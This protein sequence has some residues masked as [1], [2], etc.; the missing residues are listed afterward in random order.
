M[1]SKEIQKFYDLW[2]P[3]IASLPAV[4]NAIDT[5]EELTRSLQVRRAEFDQLEA[6]RESREAELL[7]HVDDIKLRLQSAVDQAEADKKAARASADKAKTAAAEVEKKANER[8]AAAE[9]DAKKAEQL[10]RDAE[11]SRSKVFAQI[12]E[13]ALARKNA[14]QAEIDE[15][16]NKRQEA[17]ATLNALRFKLG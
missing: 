10:Y 14:L 15:L 13:E 17:E 3:M 16:E 6:K 9:A 4:I 7:Q 5:E 12:D 11:A 2:A 1:N 8:A